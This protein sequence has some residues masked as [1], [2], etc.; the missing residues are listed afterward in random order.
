MTNALFPC[1]ASQFLY[2]MRR[3]SFAF[4][5][6]ASLLRAH[7]ELAPGNRLSRGAVHVLFQPKS[8]NTLMLLE[9]VMDFAFREDADGLIYLPA[10]DR[11]AAMV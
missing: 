7:L 6:A 2:S 11:A 10:L 9:E 5:G 1:D 3:R 4:V 8:A